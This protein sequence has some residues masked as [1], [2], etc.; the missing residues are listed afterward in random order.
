MEN[1]EQQSRNILMQFQRL[2]KSL[3]QYQQELFVIPAIILVTIL[4][5]GPIYF[6]RIY[7]S[8]SIN[9]FLLHIHFTKLILVGQYQQVPYLNLSHP[10][11]Q[12]LLIGLSFFTLHKVGFFALAVIV[13]IVVQIFIV[14]I[15]YFWFGNSAGLKNGKWFRALWAVLLTL[16]SPIM[17][18][19]FWDRLF[20]LGYIGLATYHNPTIQLLKPVALISLIFAV[21]VFTFVQNSWKVIL[22][23]ATLVV[24]SALIKPNYIMCILPALGLLSVLYVVWKK[25]LDWRLFLGG[26]LI[27]G[28]LILAIQ[29][30]LTYYFP[31]TDNN[32]IIFSP[33]G[34]MSSISSNL[35]MKLILSILFPF[36]VLIFN[37][38][39]IIRD[40][41][42]LLAW[43]GFLVSLVQTYFLAEG[44][45][46]F[47]NGNFLWGSQIMLFILFVV[48]ARYLW[49][50][51]I[52]SRSF[53]NPEKAI[54]L[55][56]FSLHVLA[57]VA[58]YV[59]LMVLAGFS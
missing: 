7:S 30:A 55:G 26:F 8:S 40:K 47:G 36:S 15:I 31:S 50:I 19:V 21:R 18:F 10:V 48:S 44:G 33:L 54:E 2:G 35:M 45:N 25:P 56:I 34:V 11:Y 42:M 28:I 53:S 46:R 17:L 3:S 39:Q 1:Y 12:L 43:L 23:S 37:F 51:K 29:Y 32:S 58:Y 52:G 41:T 22:S 24:L 49:R 13:Q 5:T 20:Y 14:L 59:S 16:V 38:Q 27:P 6:H 4:I 9:D 57:G